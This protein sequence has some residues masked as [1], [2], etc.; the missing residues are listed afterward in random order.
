VPYVEKRTCG[1]ARPIVGAVTQHAWVPFEPRAPLPTGLWLPARLDP[2]GVTGPTRGQA[3]SRRWRRVG[4]A[5]YVPDVEDAPPEQRIL[6]ATAHLPEEGAVTGWAAL[7]LR[8]GAYFDGLDRAG[9]ARPVPLLAGSSKGRRPHP[10]ITWSYEQLPAADVEELHGL[11]VATPLR[12]LFDE[13]RCLRD[14]R[15][16]TIAVDMAL[17]AS[18]VRLPELQ[19]YAEER[20]GW[21]RAGEALDAIAAARLEVRSPR[22]TELRLIWTDDAGLPPPGVNTMLFDLSGRLLGCADLFDAEAGLVIEY[23]G[24]EHL[25]DRRRAR[26]AARDEDCRA[27]GLEYTRVVASDLRRP[28]LVVRRLHAARARSLF[29]PPHQRQWTTEWPEG[30]Q[31]WF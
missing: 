10:S 8:E 1:S 5:R 24:A 29:L 12:A 2:S 26:D 15:A 20:R 6:D 28:E 13:L 25:R 3:R 27:V 14:P 22:E 23:D 9:R 30:W 4:P 16:A 18:L 21:R 7:R 31:P 11:R 17:A 19:R